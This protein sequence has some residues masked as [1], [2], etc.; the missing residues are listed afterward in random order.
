MRKKTKQI[1]F[2]HCYHHIGILIAAYCQMK[3]SSGGGHGT[4]VG[5][6]NM[7]IH[8]IMYCYYLATALNFNVGN[9]W[10]K[11]ITQAQLVRNILIRCARQF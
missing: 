7:Y 3:A 8:T 10:K 2:L 5:I 1:S 9:H 4:L 11:F 6:G